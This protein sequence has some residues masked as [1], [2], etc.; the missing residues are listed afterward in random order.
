MTN[1]SFWLRE[2]DSCVGMVRISDHADSWSI[3][4]RGHC[5]ALASSHVMCETAHRKL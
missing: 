1:E 2:F 3:Q 4:T 5:Q